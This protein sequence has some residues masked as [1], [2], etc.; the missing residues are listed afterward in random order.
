[1]KKF[2]KPSRGAPHRGRPDHRGG[3][4]AR[5]GHQHG[6]DGGLPQG[7]CVVGIHAVKELLGVRGKEISQLWL[8]ENYEDHADLAEIFE[9]AKRKGVRVQSQSAGALD[10]VV[11]AHQ[12][13]MA[14]TQE[15]PEADW[16]KIEQS[17]KCILIA[18]DEVEDPHNLGAILR[19]AWLFGAKAILTPEHRAA[20]LSPAVSKVA[21][22]AAEHVPVVRETA[23]PERLKQLKDK[24]FW[25]LGLSH[26]AKQPLYGLEVPDKVVWVLG[27]ESSGLRKSVEGACDDLIAI[28]QANPDASYNVSVAAAVAISETFRQHTR[29]QA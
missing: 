16:Q 22:G 9:L 19:T 3:A 8:R 21:Q 10:K 4:P 27:S 2:K 6:R 18:L 23:L 26:K 11:S 20:H 14:F 1:M 13:V 25:I 15:E 5:G 17:E 29:G 24:G 12:G 28:P 7:R